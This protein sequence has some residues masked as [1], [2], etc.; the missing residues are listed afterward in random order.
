MTFVPPDPTR[1][2]A[3]A[4]L[5]AVLDRGRPLEKALEALPAPTSATAPP[6]T[7]LP[8]PY[9]VGWEPWMR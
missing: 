7:G 9:S 8:R 2:A 5:S 4:L 6:R 1:D 3:F